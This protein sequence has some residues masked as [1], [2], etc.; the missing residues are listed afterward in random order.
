[1]DGPA[2]AIQTR[3]FRDQQAWGPKISLLLASTFQQQRNLTFTCR[4]RLSKGAPDQPLS[5]FIIPPCCMSRP[6][7][8]LRAII[9]YDTAASQR[10]P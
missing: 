8:N 9:Q 4:D 1:M 3:S 6:F 10:H 2:E 7:W 5:P